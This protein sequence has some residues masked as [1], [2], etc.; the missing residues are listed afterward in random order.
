[1]KVRNVSINTV[2]SYNKQIEILK[3]V[4]VNVGLMNIHQKITKE[5]IFLTIMTENS[6]ISFRL[7]CLPLEFN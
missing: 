4:R 5:Q 2:L 6:G 1:M 3:R 7:N